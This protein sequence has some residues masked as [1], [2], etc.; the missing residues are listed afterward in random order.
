MAQSRVKAPADRLHH[1]DHPVTVVRQRCLDVRHGI[2]RQTEQLGVRA[3]LSV[4]A[5]AALERRR[6]AP[7]P[8]TVVLLADALRLTP[9]ERA[10]LISAAAAQG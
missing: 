7:R 10:A 8:G 4:N 2:M 6:T 3:Q 1:D 5:V 9:A